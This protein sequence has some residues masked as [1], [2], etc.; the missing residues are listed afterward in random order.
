MDISMPVMDGYES[1]KEIRKLE[2][3]M[4]FRSYIIGLTAHNTDHYK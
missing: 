1:A 4:H 2:D 3:N